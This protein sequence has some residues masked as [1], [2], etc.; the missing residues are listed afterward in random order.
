MTVK[1]DKEAI[2]DYLEMWV[3]TFND[4]ACCP[5]YPDCDIPEDFEEEQEPGDC[6]EAILEDITCRGGKTWS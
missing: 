3:E 1:V 6:A 2:L 5:R 4:C